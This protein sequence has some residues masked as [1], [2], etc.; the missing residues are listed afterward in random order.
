MSATIIVI[1]VISMILLFISMVLSAMSASDI[2][3][4][5]TK[6]AHKYAMAS[7]LSS[8]LSIV[9][10][11]IA[12]IVYLNTGTIAQYTAKQLG[13]VAQYAQAGQ[14]R[15]YPGQQQLVGANGG[16]IPLQNV[17]GFADLR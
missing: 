1:L 5:N 4:N 2:N 11:V 12:L 3:K 10:L 6:S 17:A 8:G 16:G 13:N 9:L 7:A 15:L 14:Q